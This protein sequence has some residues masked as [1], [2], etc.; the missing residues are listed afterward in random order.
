MLNLC[1]EPGAANQAITYG[2]GPE[3]ASHSEE[4]AL[5]RD[6]I[7]GIYL[8][9]LPTGTVV[10]VDTRNSR[11]RFVML[12]GSGRN[13]LVEGGPY[14]PQQTAAHLE[15]STLGGSG[16]KVGW[17]GLGWF[18]ELSFGGKRIITSRVRSISMPELNTS[19]ERDES[20]TMSRATSQ[21]FPFVLQ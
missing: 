8:Q 6:R 20:R 5:Q 18:V 2:D 19:L 17:I 1:D 11:Y 4:F 7:S 13:V 16:L 14:F 12:D 9:A 15:G 10:G 21:A 3:P